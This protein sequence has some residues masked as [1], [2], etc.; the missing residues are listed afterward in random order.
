MDRE[1][2]EGSLWIEPPLL[3]A[4]HGPVPSLEH[5][6]WSFWTLASLAQLNVTLTNCTNYREVSCIHVQDYA[7]P[8][9]SCTLSLC[10]SILC[11]CMQRLDAASP[12]CVKSLL[13]T[14]YVRWLILRVK[15]PAKQLGT[16]I[17]RLAAIG[18]LV[19]ERT[20]GNLRKLDLSQLRES[21]TNHLATTY[22]IWSLNTWERTIVYIMDAK[23][24][25]QWL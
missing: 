10:I 17:E 21:Y 23:K 6:H 1:G 7:T 15:K 24:L 4:G 8:I 25:T 5:L 18:F 13:H 20:E 3:K 22:H 9:H 11:C 16:P 19:S 14:N 12:S 2:G